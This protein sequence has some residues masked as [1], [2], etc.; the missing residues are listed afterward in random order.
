[1]TYETL[2]RQIMGAFVDAN[3]RFIISRDLDTKA[4]ADWLVLAAG[5]AVEALVG[6]NLPAVCRVHTA[7]N[8][9]SRQMATMIADALRC[10]IGGRRS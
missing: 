4:D 1:M 10:Y 8:D 2:N 6:Y 7:D 3:T 9:L 5:P